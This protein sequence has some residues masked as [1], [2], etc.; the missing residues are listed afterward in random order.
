[1]SVVTP[2]YNQAQFLEETI[3]SV[4]SQDY[5]NVE[6]IIIDGGSTDGS[7]DIIK[8]YENRLACWVSEPDRGQSHAINKGWQRATGHIVAYLNSDDLYTPGAITV[9]V[10]ALLSNQDSCMVYSDALRIDESGR[11]LG[12]AISSPFNLQREITTEMSVPQPTVFLRREALDRVGL[13]DE[14]LHMVMDYD[15]WIRLGL[16]YPATYLPGIYMAKMR[17]HALAKSTAAVDRFPLEQR[18]VLNKLFAR[19]NVPDTL[20]QIRGRAY[21]STSFRQAIGAAYAGQ[22]QQIAQPLLRAA[23]ESPAYVARRP[24]TAYLVARI[25]IPWWPERPSPDEW[26]FIERVADHFRSRQE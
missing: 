9:A 10:Q 16:H 19:D 5:P 22:P 26:R 11:P 18:R 24:F 20:R 14:S 21:S 13:L 3:L 2:S 17:E 7:V 6:Y 12:K 1:V 4:L 8:R 25:L 15:L 23:L